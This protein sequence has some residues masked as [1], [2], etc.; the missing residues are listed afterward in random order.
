MRKSLIVGLLL[1]ALVSFVF[2]FYKVNSENLIIEKERFPMGTI[3]EIKVPV[4]DKER[5]KDTETAISKAFEEIERVENIFSVF[6]KDSEI[7][8]INNLKSG[9]RLA[10]S[11]EAFGL[12]EKAI[13]FN[14]KT[15]G[16]FDI[17]IK[18]LVDLWNKAKIENRMPTDD[19]LKAALA[20]VGSDKITLDKKERTISFEK[21]GMAIDMGGIAKGYATARAIKV[22][23]ECNIKNAIVNSG[24]DMY[25]LGSKS[26]K[27]MWRVGI[28]HPRKRNEVIFEIGLKDKAIDTSGDYEKFFIYNGKRYS[29]IIDPR[30]GYP[31]GDNAVSATII[32]E[33]SVTADALATALCILGRKGL[34][35]INSMKDVD[36]II[37]LKEGDRLKSGM[38]EGLERRYGIVKKKSL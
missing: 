11:D 7:S 26:G 27:E 19:E 3:V 15:E 25:C 14:K 18:P 5:I 37:I 20:K 8:R 33:D 38:S 4:E 23:K 35:I 30:T 22:L 1:G 28:Q 16:A 34:E 32:A 21:E 29:H 13:E 24:G 31:I 36:V 12:I 17:T 10:L 6:K 9:E 2:L